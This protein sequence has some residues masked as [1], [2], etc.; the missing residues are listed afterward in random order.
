MSQAGILTTSG[1][2]GGTINSVTGNNGVTA[3]TVAGAVTVSGVNATTSTVGV[4]SFNPG[5]FTVTAGGQVSIL[6]AGGFIWSDV[7]GA[8]VSAP[9][10]GY[11]V[12][13]AATTTLPVGVNG[14]TLEFILDVSATL[15]I[16]AGAGQTIR[17]G[18]SVS[19]TNG[20]AKNSTIGSTVELIF[21]GTNSQWCAG[22]NNGSWTL[23]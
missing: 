3:S 8:F 4:A 2:G 23:A 14:N 10:N 7:S 20:T 5:E 11:F 22:D 21:R 6:N 15:V 12:M 18:S 17:I 13:G 19:S 9:T 1:G 16:T